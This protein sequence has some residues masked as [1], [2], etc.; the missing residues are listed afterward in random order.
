MQTLP[1]CDLVLEVVI[2]NPE[3]KKENLQTHRTDSEAR[4]ERYGQEQVGYLHRHVAEG[5]TNP[6]RFVGIHLFNPCQMPLVELIKG[7]RRVMS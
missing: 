4:G 3:A 6:D 5:L 1:Q 2:E 7:P